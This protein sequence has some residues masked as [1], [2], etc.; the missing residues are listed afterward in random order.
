[1]CVGQGQG[2]AVIWENLHAKSKKTSKGKT[3][4]Q[5]KKK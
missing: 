3:V 2:G 4:A 5:G 1:M